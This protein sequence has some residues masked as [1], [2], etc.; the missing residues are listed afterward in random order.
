[1]EVKL[2]ITSKTHYAT[3]ALLD[4]AFHQRQGP[5]SLPEI[6]T[7]QAISLS[8]LEQLFARLRQAGL[9]ASARG[10][11]GGYR[12]GRQPETISMANIADA[13]N[14]SVDTTRCHGQ[15]NCQQG[16]TCLSHHLWTDLSNHIHQF[17]DS[18][19]LEDLITRKHRERTGFPIQSS[20]AS[21]IGH[22]I[23][24]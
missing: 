1:M 21:T 19:S 4:L 14:E 18:I 17:L 8:Y 20:V 2:R 24:R 23:Q 10:R 9:V 13:I 5:V 7:R 3:T 15:S 22:D 6:A 11:R 16:D 12:L